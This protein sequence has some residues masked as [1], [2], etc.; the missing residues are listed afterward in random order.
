[1]LPT[2]SPPILV[3]SR[4]KPHLILLLILSVLSGISVFLTDANPN[5]PDWLSR[6]WGISLLLSGVTALVAHLQRTDRER[7]MYVERGALALQSGAVMVYVATLTSFL[8][9][10]AEIFITLLAGIAWAGANMWEVK[11]ISSD[12]KM[13]HAI[14]AVTPTLEVDD[15]A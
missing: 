15:A 2:H 12:L 8:P 1:M 3:L 6:M 9:W 14:R 4:K 7:G 13:I 5:V 11:L 10:G